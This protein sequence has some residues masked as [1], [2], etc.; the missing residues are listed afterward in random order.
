MQIYLITPAAG[1]KMGRFLQFPDPQD[2][3]I[4]L[5]ELGMI[6]E[7]LICGDDPQREEDPFCSG[8]DTQTWRGI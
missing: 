3:R 4:Q 6:K 7:S 1:A 2:V 8:M 5:H